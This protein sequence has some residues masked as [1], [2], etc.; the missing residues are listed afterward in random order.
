MLA[1]QFLLMDKPVTVAVSLALTHI[2]FE[3]TLR[4][5]DLPIFVARAN[6]VAEARPRVCR[7]SG[8]LKAAEVEVADHHTSQVGD[9]ADS[10]AAAA[11]RTQERDSA[12]DHDEVF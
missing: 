10:A 3:F 7:T 1:C 8:F 2:D 4:T 12:D 9:V 11:E 5:L 6:R